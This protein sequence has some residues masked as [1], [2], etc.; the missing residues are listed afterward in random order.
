MSKFLNIVTSGN[1]ATIFLYG[2]ISEWKNDIRPIDI[3]RELKEAEAAYKNID[4]RI[5]SY[6]GN[7]HAGIAI[8]NA[9][10][11][12][13]TSINI[14]V[15]G[16]AASMAS[17]IALCGKPVQ[18]SKYARLMLHGVSGGCYGTKSQLKKT[19]QEMESLE[20]TL[21]EMYG[22]RTGKTAEE[23]KAT[24]FDGKDH[25]LT[26]NEALSLGF[27]DGIYDAEPID[28]D[29]PT[30]ETIYKTFNNRLQSQKTDNHMNLDE[31]KKRPYFANCAT[32]NDVLSAIAKLEEEAAKVPTLTASL[33]TANEKVQGFEAKAKEIAD[34]AKKE[35]LDAAEKDGRINATTRPTY[36]ALLNAD[37]ENGQAALAALTPKKRASDEIHVSAGVGEGAWAK[38]QAEIRN[39]LKK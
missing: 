3:A 15:D 38:R 26:A 2:D 36:E 5:N 28:E 8:F 13:K 22:K 30:T 39:N 16:I 31:I 33:N 17:A 10:R 9:I 14:Y 12:S 21:A 35:L 7:V 19:I 25:W 27:I 34:A 23:I 32:D 20:N 6:G 24:Y 29:N 11:N 37:L 1:T 18:M 4:L